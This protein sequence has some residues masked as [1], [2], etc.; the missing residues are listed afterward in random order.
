M[1]TILDETLCKL[2]GAPVR[3]YARANRGYFGQDPWVTAYVVLPWTKK[4]QKIRDQ[5]FAKDFS[6]DAPVNGGITFEETES[7]GW[8]IGWD[9][10]HSFNVLKGTTCP[11]LDQIRAEAKQLVDLFREE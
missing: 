5:W 10:N 3:V 11:T 1:N 8:T 2:E 9:Y 4:V 7:S 6:W